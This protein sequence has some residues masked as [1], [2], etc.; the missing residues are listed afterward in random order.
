MVERTA[1]LAMV[2]ADGVIAALPPAARIVLRTAD[3]GAV[4]VGLALALG[5]I[6]NRATTTGPV[7][8]LH[9]GPDE[10]LL[11][12][13]PDAAAALLAA[14]AGLP[15]AMVDVSHRSTAIEVAGPHATTILAAFCAL[16]LAAPAFPV[17]MC[18]RTLF[19]KAEIILW[20]T[21]ATTFRIDVW[22][23]FA[24]HVRDCLE[25]ARREFS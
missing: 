2:D 14:G 8:A 22:R 20:R 12:A 25:E 21:A 11:L 10:W 4:A 5:T 6:I 1:P 3:P 19:G 16:D 15:A 24:P 18:S 17:G 13:P 7:T 23:S 9:L